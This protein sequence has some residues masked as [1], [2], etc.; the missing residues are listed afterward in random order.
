MVINV[1]LKKGQ[2]FRLSLLRHFQRPAF[3]INAL[4][5][6]GFTAYAFTRGPLILMLIGWL[7]LTVYIVS[8]IITAAQ[9]AY[10]KDQTHLLPTR[11]EF[12]NQ[13][14]QISNTQNKQSTVGWDILP[15]GTACWIVTC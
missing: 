12:T 3:Y 9:A 15:V 13:G 8:G 2:V 14:V 7:P 5:F 1:Q 10:G 4:A 6:A 11:Y